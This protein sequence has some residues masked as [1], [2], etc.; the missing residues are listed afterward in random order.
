MFDV[1]HP[2][3]VFGQKNSVSVILYS[4]VSFFFA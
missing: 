3:V 4:N 1:S 2:A